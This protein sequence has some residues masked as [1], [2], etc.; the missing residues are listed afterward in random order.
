M[1]NNKIERNLAKSQKQITDAASKAVY[2]S[3]SDQ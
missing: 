2:P 3:G 1:S